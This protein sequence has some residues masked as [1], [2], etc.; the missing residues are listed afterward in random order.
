MKGVH[1]DVVVVGGGAAG[2]MAAGTAARQ[3]A[4]TM[5]I[6]RMERPGRKLRI[7][8][9]GRCNLTNAAPAADF[10]SH[11][12]RN[13]RFLR[14]AF[15]RFFVDDLMAFFSSLGIETV[16]E[17]GGR[18]FPGRV[19]APEVTESLIKWVSRSGVD[20]V[21]GRRVSGL[22]MEGGGARGVVSG[23][24]SSENVTTADAIIL[25]TGGASYPST[26]STGDGYEL[27][28]SVGHT[29]IPVRPALVPL[30]TLERWPE[31]V[32]GLTLRNTGV[33]VLADGKKI[34]GGFGEVFF[35][36]GS[37]GGPV[38]LTLSGRIVDAVNQRKKVRI[39]FDLKPALDEKKLEA[40]LLRELSGCGGGSMNA[41]FQSLLPASLIPIVAEAAGIELGAACSR[42][43]ARERRRLR[44]ILKDLRVTVTGHRGFSEAIVTAGG[45]STREID[46]YTMRSRLVRGLFFAGEI[47]DINGDTGGYNLQAAFST[48]WLAGVSAACQAGG[49]G[50]C[51]D[52]HA[53]RRRQ[54]GCGR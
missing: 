40:R 5:L 44:M 39:S 29:V 19:G 1:Y 8:G 22:V 33:K 37:I 20:V 10:I 34:G 18:V 42:I 14:Q 51:R 2:L 45:V 47:I 32:C 43:T 17:R 41:V 36:G 31:R 3:G 50:G 38:P 24:C 23:R 13:G 46:P 27:A 6:E 26:G 7:T 28:R 53:G 15:S 9:K 21:P 30:V 48:G 11:F 4:R 16:V 49:S 54:G 25:A 12:G 52:E 35:S